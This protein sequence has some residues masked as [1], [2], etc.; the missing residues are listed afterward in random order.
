MTS[1]P[2][3]QPKAI[4]TRV[5]ERLK[6]RELRVWYLLAAIFVL[7]R[8]PAWLNA[9][10]TNSDGAV[11][12]LQA[13]QIFRGELTWLHWG[14]TYLTCIDSIVLVPFFGVIAYALLHDTPAPSDRVD[15]PPE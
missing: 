6:A 5:W 11:T 9:G 2:A 3:V 4:A 15:R 14:R 1:L 13:L 12:G 10:W 8:V 7:F